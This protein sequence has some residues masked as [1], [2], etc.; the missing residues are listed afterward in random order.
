MSSDCMGLELK[1]GYEFLLLI[2]TFGRMTS[3]KTHNNNKTHTTPKII[4]FPGSINMQSNLSWGCGERV[5]SL[6]WTHRK[7][8]TNSKNGPFN[9]FRGPERI[10]V[11]L[12]YKT[13]FLIALL[14]P[15]IHINKVI[16][17]ITNL[18]QLSVHFQWFQKA[19]FFSSRR[20]NRK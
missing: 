14:Y 1:Q 7:K 20:I 12:L 17:S 8:P 4:L 13:V 6:K 9:P 5:E 2:G 15:S 10:H 3:H 16:W 11:L 19:L 18:A